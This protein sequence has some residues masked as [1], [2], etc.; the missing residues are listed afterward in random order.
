MIS[1]SGLVN[2]KIPI[3]L[4]IFLAVCVV[5]ASMDIFNG[6]GYYEELFSF[7]ETDAV[8]EKWGFFGIGDSNFINNSGSYFVIQLGMALYLLF[9]YLIN[10][11]CVYSARYSLARKIG[12][13]VYEDN[14]LGS[15]IDGVVKL[16]LESYFDIVICTF[17]NLT[18]FI[19]AKNFDDFK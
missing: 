8:G 4:H 5:F 3:H 1:L 7:K 11:I 6:E 12:I 10:K 19:R 15:F 9:F 2:V 18:A 13:F 14:Y 17:I 16:F